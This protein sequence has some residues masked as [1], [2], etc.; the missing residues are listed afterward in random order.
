MSCATSASANGLVGNH[1]Y[2]L[3]GNVTL[4]NNARLIRIRNPWGNTEWT[5]AYSDKD[6]L[7]STGTY[8]SQAG[9]SSKD[10][11]DFFM[12]VEDYVKYFSFQTFNYNPD[13]LFH[14]YWLAVG[15]GDTF[16]VNGTTPYCGS[17]CK[18]TTFTV[19]SAVD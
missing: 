14:S 10:D 18:R 7:W 15:N 3:L 16:G 9:F 1:A 6:A 5:G 8:A 11:G 17:T 13:N 2:T 12:T 4:S 19:T